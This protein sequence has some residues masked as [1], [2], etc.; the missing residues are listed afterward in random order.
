MGRRS[1]G[2]H[3]VF[4]AGRY[5]EDEEAGR[6]QAEVAGPSR[7]GEA[8][9][10]PG[11][12]DASD[13]LP[14]DEVYEGFPE[15]E[16]EEPD[17]DPGWDGAD[18]LPPDD[19]LDEGPTDAQSSQQAGASPATGGFQRVASGTIPFDALM[20]SGIPWHGFG[21]VHELTS[22]ELGQRGEVLAAIYLEARGYDIEERNYTCP[23]GE[24]DIIARI[25][26]EYVFV[27]V[28]TRL[29][30]G[31][32]DWRIVPELAVDG[33]KQDRY[34]RIALYYLQERPQVERAR[35]DVVAIS[36]RGSVQ[37]HLRHYAGAFEMEL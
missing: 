2:S 29:D 18:D 12:P 14:P 37:G 5:A 16:G 34:R 21:P 30:Q 3:M 27:E 13:D 32:P 7:A 31:G 10:G 4:G 6:V 15:S 26:G 11:G 24:A 20:H 19:A 28:K 9:L 22:R 8:S 35:F 36:V 23:F 1:A 25:D 33:R 17:A